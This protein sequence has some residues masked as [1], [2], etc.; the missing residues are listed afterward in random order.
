MSLSLLAARRTVIVD[1]VPDDVDTDDLDLYFCSKKH[2]GGGP[3]DTIA[4]KSN[5]VIVEFEEEQGM[6]IIL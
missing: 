1:D 3:V 6:C 4:R 2:S 5:Q